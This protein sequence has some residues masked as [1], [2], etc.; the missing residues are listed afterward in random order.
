VEPFLKLPHIPPI[1]WAEYCILL[2]LSFRFLGASTS[3][4][5]CWN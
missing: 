5:S 1:L 4:R 3:T 2:L